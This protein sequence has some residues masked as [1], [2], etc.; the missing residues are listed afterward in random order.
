MLAKKLLATTA[1]TPGI[2]SDPYLNYVSMLL[3]ADGT[4][5]ASNNIFVDGSSNNYAITPANLV[6]QGSVNPYGDKWSNYFNGITTNL[7][8]PDNNALDLTN[9]FTIECWLYW[10]PRAGE[11]LPR[12][13]SKGKYQGGATNWVMYLDQATGNLRMAWGSGTDAILIGTTTAFTWS[14]IAVS[15]SSGVIKTFF[16]GILTATQTVP[17]SF[18]GGSSVRVGADDATSTNTL[19]SG[20]I[21]NVRIIKD[22]SLYNT[23]FT[24]STSVLTAVTNTSLLTCQSNQFIDKSVYAH[25][26][27]IVGTPKVARFSPFKE[28]ENYSAGSISFNDNGSNLQ[29]ASQANLAPN[30][31]NFTWEAW[32]YPN[33]FNQASD[34]GDTLWYTGTTGG[35]LIGRPSTGNG[36]S[37]GIG[38]T[39]Q[40]WR[41]LSNTLPINGQWNHIAVSRIG[42]GGN[43]T[44]LWLNGQNVS[45]GAVTQSFATGAIGISSGYIPAGLDG[46]LSDIRFIKGSALY[47]PAVNTYTVPTEPLTA[48]TNTNLLLSGRNAAVYDSVSKANIG[49]D[50]TTVKLDTTIKKFGTASLSF[51]GSGKRV[52]KAYD[53]LLDVVTGTFTF[54]AWIYPTVSSTNNRIF[55]TGG[56][57]ATWN[58]TNGIHILV[59]TASGKLNLQLSTNTATP[60]SI[61]T[62]DD[63]PINQWS[64]VTVSVIDNTAYLGV[65]GNVLS[66][67][68]AGRARPSTNP[69]ANLGIIPGETLGSSSEYS[70]YMDEI[71]FTTGIARYTA[72]FTPPTAAFPTI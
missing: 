17:N 13:L 18:S 14:H 50:T 7:N 27:N 1:Q 19:W 42:L 58:A 56:G 15:R 9:D 48:V 68:V 47:D 29:I 41:L 53:P 30:L 25:S 5:G 23:S 11:T 40:V 63:I 26:I 21:S 57:S 62:T 38:S 36:N 70:G 22:L 33:S 2:Q 55:A 67:S 61:L 8:I 31:S 43:Q 35:L 45:R 6:T 59:Q 46:W 39:G 66:G 24:P 10:I 3:H 49:T 4:N 37:W 34:G 65:N 72:N 12:F 32:F 69:T 51:T 28:T 64:F 16:N 54:E 44:A 20:Y 52:S 71:R 60:I